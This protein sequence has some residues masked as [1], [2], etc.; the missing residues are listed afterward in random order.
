MPGCSVSKT[1][2]A[3]LASGRKSLPICGSDLPLS[4]LSRG[5]MRAIGYHGAQFAYDVCIG[6]PRSCV[7]SMESDTGRAPSGRSST[8]SSVHARSSQRVES[9]AVLL[10]RYAASKDAEAFGELVRRH[11][12]LVYATALLIVRDVHEA[13]DVAQTCFLELAKKAG[14]VKR[15]LPGWLHSLSTS[16]AIDSARR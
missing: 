3:S 14:A 9:D 6:G 10:T 16:R 11:S 15:S 13:E 4:S 8:Q 12:G 5:D 7:L 1:L 2:I